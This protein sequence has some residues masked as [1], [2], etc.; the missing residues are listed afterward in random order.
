M[1]L[2]LF[3]SFSHEIQQHV[4]DEDGCKGDPPA[5]FVFEKP[6]RLGTEMVLYEE[7]LQVLLL[8]HVMVCLV[9]EK[10]IGIKV[11]KKKNK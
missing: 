10:E 4:S 2:F 6:F 5:S 8:L 9:L 3:F 11:Q 7:A 1:F